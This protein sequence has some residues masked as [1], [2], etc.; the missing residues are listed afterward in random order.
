VTPLPRTS[1]VQHGQGIGR[2]EPTRQHKVSLS[3]MMMAMTKS[4]VATTTSLQSSLVHSS[5]AKF[6]L[7][8]RKHGITQSIGWKSVKPDEATHC[9]GNDLP[10]GL[11]KYVH[12]CVDKDSHGLQSC[13]HVTT[14]VE[15][16]RRCAPLDI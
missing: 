2:R 10:P 3:S 14:V 4:L 7:K 9:S 11:I 5:Q 6:L 13:N 16:A 8:I 15:Q 12:Q 1:P